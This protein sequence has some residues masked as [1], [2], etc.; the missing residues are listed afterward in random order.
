M[1]ILNILGKVKLFKHE[2]IVDEWDGEPIFEGDEYFGSD[3]FTLKD[4]F[5]QIRFRIKKLIR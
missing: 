4:L 3:H 5:Y 2:D 1:K